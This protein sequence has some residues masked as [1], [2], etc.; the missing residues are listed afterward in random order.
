ML[1]TYEYFTNAEEGWAPINS[2]TSYNTVS[3]IMPEF[4]QQFETLKWQKFSA[5]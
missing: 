5:V 1:F 3:F 4:F 2:G